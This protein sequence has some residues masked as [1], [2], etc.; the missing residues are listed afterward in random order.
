MLRTS[1]LTDKMS[2]QLQRIVRTAGYALGLLLFAAIAYAS[3]PEAF[4][5][6]KISEYE[7]EGSLR[8]YTWPV[9]FLIVSTAIFSTIAYAAMMVADWTGGL[10]DDNALT[11]H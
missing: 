8:I 10:D 4:D 9:R 11:T 5:A 3:I 1:L 2:P 6:F 7:G